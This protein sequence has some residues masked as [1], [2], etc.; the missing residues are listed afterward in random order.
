M[1]DRAQRVATK[2][3][4]FRAARHR[5]RLQDGALQSLD[6]GQLQGK[7]EIFAHKPKATQVQAPSRSLDKSEGLL[8]LD[9]ESL[10]LADFVF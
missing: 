7:G 3:Q 8:V 1:L 5:G 10:E 4:A 9:L 6:S 2:N